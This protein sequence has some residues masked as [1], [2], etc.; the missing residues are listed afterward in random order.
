[1]RIA[2]TAISTVETTGPRVFMAE[3]ITATAYQ[4][5]N[6]TCSVES[7]VPFTVHW[8]FGSIIIGGPFFYQ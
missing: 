7:R 6:L 8:L 1:M 4:P 3:R 2:P 5:V